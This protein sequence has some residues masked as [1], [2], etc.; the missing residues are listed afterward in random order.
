MRS[1]VDYRRWIGCLPLVFVLTSAF[2]PAAQAAASDVDANQW[3][4]EFTPYIW[5]T[6]QSG[7]VGLANGPGNGRSFNQSFSDILGNMDIGGMAAF[8]AR[9]GRWGLFL[10]GI[11]LR[12]SDRGSISGPNGLVSLSANGNVT[13]QQYSVAGYYRALEGQTTLDALAGIRYNN[14]S[15]NVD[16]SLTSPLLP[17]TVL[18]QNFSQNYGW[19]DPI[20]GVRVRHGFD[21]RWSVVGYADI[22]GSGAG[23][24]LTWQILGGV[25][26]AFRP[27][28]IGKLGY[29]YSSIYYRS[30]GFSYDVATSGF[31]A[32]V[33]F[34]W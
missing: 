17:G 3:H 8:E 32:G 23:S 26:Y 2:I 22:G 5:A 14:V 15:W 31:Y 6:G 33:G 30:S 1:R 4:L 20:V 25:N 7:T 11:Y 28:V 10:D 19:V 12:V 24:N 16:A 34:T 13:Q 18:S 29:R 9:N 27:D 21:E